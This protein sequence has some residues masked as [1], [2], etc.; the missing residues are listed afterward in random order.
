[1]LIREPEAVSDSMVYRIDIMPVAASGCL[2]QDH[3]EATGRRNCSLM[4]GVSGL[5]CQKSFIAA[6]CL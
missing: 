2:T 3:D 1:M 4:S 6:L 5:A